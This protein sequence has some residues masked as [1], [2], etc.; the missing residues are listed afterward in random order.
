FRLT[1][2]LSRTD[3]NRFLAALPPQRRAPQRSSQSTMSTNAVVVQLST[4]GSSTLGSSKDQNHDDIDASSNS[5][6]EQTYRLPVLRDSSMKEGGDSDVVI[7]TMAR[8]VTRRQGLLSPIPATKG[9]SLPH[10]LVVIGKDEHHTDYLVVLLCSHKRRSP[11]R[12]RSTDANDYTRYT[13]GRFRVENG[14]PTM[15]LASSA[16]VHKANA[17]KHDPVKGS[18]MP[19]KL[20][21]RDFAKLL[22]QSVG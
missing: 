3:P 6:N 9:R 15:I 11:F 19:A 7:A 10:P 13:Q 1:S 16:L 2:I 8:D 4:T 17:L 5:C 21:K 14:K 20:D 12:Q 18:R 22:E